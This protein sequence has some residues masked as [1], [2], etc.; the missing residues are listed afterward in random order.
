MQNKMNFPKFSWSYS[1]DQTF[2]QCPRKYYYE[3]YGSYIGENDPDGDERFKAAYRLKHLTN[4]P[5]LLGSIVHEANSWV[6]ERYIGKSNL[7]SEADY[8]KFIQNKC[9]LLVTKMNT[10]EWWKNPKK[11]IMLKEIYEHKTLSEKE[12]DEI[13]IH[14]EVCSN[15]FYN[16]QTLNEI[17]KGNVSVEEI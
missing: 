14:S 6:I 3:Y 5:N 4:I 12:F 1:R 16:S 13:A 11:H 15:N 7:L 17:I 8:Q 10:E 9:K 2:M